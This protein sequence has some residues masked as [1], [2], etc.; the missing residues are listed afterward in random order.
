MNILVCETNPAERLDIRLS[1][2]V[3][4]AGHL[5]GKSQ[6]SPGMLWQTGRA[7]LRGNSVNQVIVTNLYPEVVQVRLNSVMTL[8]YLGNYHCHHLPLGP[9]QHF[10]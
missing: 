10:G 6:D 5:L 4:G 3:G 7:P 8:I 9:P 1:Q 2:P